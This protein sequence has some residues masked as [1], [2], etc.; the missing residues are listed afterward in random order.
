MSGSNARKQGTEMSENILWRDV[1]EWDFLNEQEK[2][3]KSG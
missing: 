2:H 3:M 1:H